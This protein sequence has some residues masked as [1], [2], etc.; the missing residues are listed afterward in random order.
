MRL[1]TIFLLVFGV[2]AGLFIPDVRAE[3]LTLTTYYPAP[4]GVYD[5]VRLVPR[6]GSPGSCSGENK[7]ML[8]T[9]DAVRLLF[10]GPNDWT[11]LD[12]WT[13]EGTNVYPTEHAT[14]NVGIGTDS[15]TQKLH[16]AGGDALFEDNVE[17][18]QDLG[19]SGSVGVGTLT[20][21]YRMDV[22]GDAKVNKLYMNP[23]G[24]GVGELKV[25]YKD[26]AYYMPYAPPN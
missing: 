20:P 23:E 22:N 8:Y 2:F 16:V 17:I 26:G 21:A 19:V 1:F 6:D 24:Q 10:C 14:V 4:F 5:R 25:I 13:Q 9:N 7:G 3:N 18:Q 11:V 12:V 15:P